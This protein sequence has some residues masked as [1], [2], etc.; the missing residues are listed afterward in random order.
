[1]KVLELAHIATDDNYIYYRRN[2]TATAKLQMLSKTLDVQISFTI[3]T[4]PLGDKMLY[5]DILNSANIDYPLIPVK[6]ALKTYILELENE[7]KLPC[8]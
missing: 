3:E 4:G 8:G 6:S 2:Y 5:V 1:M 7:G